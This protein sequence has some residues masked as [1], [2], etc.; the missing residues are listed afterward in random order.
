LRGSDCR[1]ICGLHRGQLLHI[2]ACQLRG[3]K[4]TDLSCGQSG[5][6]G[7]AQLA[8]LCSGQVAKS[9]VAMADN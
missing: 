5:H 4:L 8:H 6:L 1:Q 7:V 9:A 2:Q 3:A